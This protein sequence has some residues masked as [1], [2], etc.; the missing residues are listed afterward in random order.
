MRFETM[1]RRLHIILLMT[2]K[3]QNRNLTSTT[4]DN[5]SMVGY[6]EVSQKRA[7]ETS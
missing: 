7:C 5:S 2:L 4:G 3:G 6:T 1:G